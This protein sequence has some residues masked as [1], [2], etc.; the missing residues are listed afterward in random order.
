MNGLGQVG[1]Q[2]K[3]LYLTVGT[4]YDARETQGS[5]RGVHLYIYTCIYIYMYFY[6][7]TYIYIYIYTY[8]YVYT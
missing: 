3:T 4:D 1:Y 5:W 7:Y 6:V 2:L 8:I